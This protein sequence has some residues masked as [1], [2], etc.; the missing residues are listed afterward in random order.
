MSSDEDT[1]SEDEDVIDFFSEI[2]KPK[3]PVDADTEQ[4]DERLKVLNEKGPLKWIQN[5]IR[6]YFPNANSADLGLSKKDPWMKWASSIKLVWD[7]LIRAGLRWEGNKPQFPEMTSIRD[8]WEQEKKDNISQFK[9]TIEEYL[10]PEEMKKYLKSAGPD[11]DSDDEGE[12]A[13]DVEEDYGYRL[14]ESETRPLIVRT[15]NLAGGPEERVEWTEPTIDYYESK[16]TDKQLIG[17]YLKNWTGTMITGEY[18]ELKGDKYDMNNAVE[19]FIFEI[20]HSEGW[21]DR[22]KKNKRILI[23]IREAIEKKWKLTEEPA[24]DKIPEKKPEKE[25]T[26]EEYKQAV[27]NKLESKKKKGD[28]EGIAKYEK[29][30][31]KIKLEETSSSDEDT[32]DSDSDSEAIALAL[33]DDSDGP[34]GFGKEWTYEKLLANTDPFSSFKLTHAQILAHEEEEKSKKILEEE[35]DEEKLWLE[36]LDPEMLEDLKDQIGDYEN[37]TFKEKKEWVEEYE[38]DTPYTSDDEEEEAEGPEPWILSL[39]KGFNSDL[40]EYMVNNMP[41]WYAEASDEE[42][43]KFYKEHLEEFEETGE[44]ETGDEDSEE[45]EDEEDEEEDPVTKYMK[46]QK[47]IEELEGVSAVEPSKVE[48]EEVAV[49]VKKI[50][51][52]GIT[53]K[54]HSDA[55]QKII[56]EAEDDEIDYGEEGGM[57]FE[58]GAGQTEQAETSSEEEDEVE[59][60]F[61]ELIA[62][63]SDDDS[64]DDDSSEEE[65]TDEDIDPLALFALESSDED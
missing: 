28:E 8:Q 60:T 20:K 50:K 37:K 63:S 44:T 22:M 64:S 53:K 4:T 29:L 34:Y 13:E 2:D 65:S 21:F 9:A 51:D 59:K 40:V 27:I 54:S 58:A 11:P 62:E 14:S 15:G 38:D 41:K 57:S 31:I 42:K 17:H 25:Q 52:K 33:M 48:I 55:I 7:F 16:L 23:D 46:Q 18:K 26:A 24:P 36:S 10:T 32:S 3:E 30:L 12:Y 49:V 45:E 6:I 1:S 43:L 35:E 19:G 56:D 61:A 39:A 5:Q 47:E